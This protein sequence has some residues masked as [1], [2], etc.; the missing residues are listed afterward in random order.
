MGGHFRPDRSRIKE[1]GVDR[2]CAEWLL[3]CG[4]HVRWV[5]MEKWQTDYNT[6]PTGSARPKIA[7]IDANE[8]AVMEMGF[9][10]LSMLWN[11]IFFYSFKPYK[12]LHKC[13]FL[14]NVK[15]K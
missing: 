10:H 13:V 7:E 8:A 15:C 2:A 1:V 11:W 9:E 3:R 5:G 14:D 6:L 12:P 4:A